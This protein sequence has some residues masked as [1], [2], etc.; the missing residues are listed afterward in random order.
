MA[1]LILKVYERDK[2]ETKSVPFEID[3]DDFPEF[4]P[5]HDA[6]VSAL[7]EEILRFLEDYA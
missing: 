4:D 3:F 2:D 1:E 7:E 5:T 6:H